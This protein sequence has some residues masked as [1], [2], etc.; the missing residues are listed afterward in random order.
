MDPYSAVKTKLESLE[1]LIRNHVN[2]DTMTMLQLLSEIKSSVKTA[3]VNGQ[4]HNIHDAV[5]PASMM[6]SYTS[7]YDQ[8][9]FDHPT[10]TPCSSLNQSG[11]E[12]SLTQTGMPVFQESAVYFN[13]HSPVSDEM[14]LYTNRT[15]ISA[16]S[17][18]PE[19]VEIRV[20]EDVYHKL[21]KLKGLLY[22]NN[23]D[24]VLLDELTGL[25]K[26]F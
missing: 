10:P 21:D 22:K 15:D 16:N 26:L 14:P 18:S 5:Q 11:I 25:L 7:V 1:F 12:S 19:L 6:S 23:L 20:D 24:T 9:E 4:L 13:Q 8:T 2:D 3:Y 17:G